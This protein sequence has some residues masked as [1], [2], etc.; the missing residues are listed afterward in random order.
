MPI[1]G[2][3][4]SSKTGNLST[5]AFE[6]IATVTLGSSSSSINFTSIPS[7]YQYLQLRITGRGGRALFLDNILMSFNND[8]STSNYWN[9]GLYGDGSTVSP[10][11]DGTSYILMYS[12]AGAN[13]GSN[14]FG[15]MIVDIIDYANTNKNKTV[16]FLGG[17]D[18]NGTGIMSFGGGA[19]FSTQAINS[20]Q[21]SLST[22]SSF[23]TGTQAALYGIKG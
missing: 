8:S 11:N 13:A 19:W 14:I 16:K 12:L 15:T 21:M 4:D 17:I 23:Q 22:G 3:F 20:I 18:N 9:H 7:T 2:I 10:S 1:L 6:S 5:T